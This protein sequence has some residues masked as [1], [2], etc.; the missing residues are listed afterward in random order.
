MIEIKP[1]RFGGSEIGQAS[2]D[3]PSSLGVLAR[4]CQ[5][6]F[7]VAKEAGRTHHCLPAPQ[8]GRFDGHR[9]ENVGGRA[10]GWIGGASR[11]QEH[12]ETRGF[13]GPEQWRRL[14][15]FPSFPVGL[16]P[17]LQQQALPQ[18]PCVVA[19]PQLAK[20]A[21]RTT[22][23]QRIPTVI[24]QR[25]ADDISVGTYQARRAREWPHSSQDT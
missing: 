2:G 6:Q 12:S 14:S 16:A 3:A 9:D 25:K 18:Q 21:G 11:L 19:R 13:S 1:P 23:E 17:S 24:R 8:T 7:Q 15:A 4:K 5:M 20:T 22:R 10:G